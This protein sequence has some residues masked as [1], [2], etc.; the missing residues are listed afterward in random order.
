MKKLFIAVLLVGFAAISALAEPPTKVKTGA[1][2]SSVGRFEEL[3]QTGCIPGSCYTLVLKFVV[4]IAAP[5]QAPLYITKETFTGTN[6][7][8]IEAAWCGARKIRKE[9][10]IVF[11]GE[12]EVNISPESI[13]PVPVL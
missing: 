10:V 4:N 13:R 3:C 1:T 6:Y 11:D 12:N 7:P 8:S 2:E 9:G 5:E